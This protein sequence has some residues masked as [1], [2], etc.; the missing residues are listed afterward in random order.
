MLWKGLIIPT[1]RIDKLCDELTGRF[2]KLKVKSPID[3]FNT[4]AKCEHFRG[5][6]N[7]FLHGWVSG[8]SRRIANPRFRRFESDLMLQY[9]NGDMAKLVARATLRM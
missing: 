6:H 3:K 5:Q 7:I 4:K 1:L 2:A 9:S 8:L